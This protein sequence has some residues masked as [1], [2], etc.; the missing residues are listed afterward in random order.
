M[1]VGIV[2]THSCLTYIS[3]NGYGQGVFVYIPRHCDDPSSYTSSQVRLHAFKHGLTYLPAINQKNQVRRVYQRACIFLFSPCHSYLQ[4]KT[5]HSF[6]IFSVSSSISIIIV[7]RRKIVLLPLPDY[8][9]IPEDPAGIRWGQGGT[10]I[11][12]LI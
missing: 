10:A 12:N 2:D 3:G 1:R 6:E 7:S 8:K 5:I 4:V 11:S 9:R